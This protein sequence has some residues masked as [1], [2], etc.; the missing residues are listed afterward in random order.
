[1]LDAPDLDL[2][3]K[4]TYLAA[5]MATRS[6]EPDAVAWVE[7]L[8]DYATISMEIVKPRRGDDPRV[9]SARIAPN[10][11]E[12]PKAIDEMVLEAAAILKISRSSHTG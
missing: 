3:V 1:M 9:I 2:G 7:M 12:V 10:G 11:P 4:A 8:S 5:K 6:P